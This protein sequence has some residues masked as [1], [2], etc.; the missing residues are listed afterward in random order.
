[1]GFSDYAL[2]NE[3]L[4]KYKRHPRTGYEGP[5]RK[6]RYSCALSCNLSTRGHWVVSTLP[7]LLYTHERDLAP[8]NKVLVISEF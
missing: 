6:E 5:E 8:A 2:R 7:W 3:L 1:M 4:L